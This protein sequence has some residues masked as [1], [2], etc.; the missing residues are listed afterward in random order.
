MFD[1]N[2]DKRKKTVCKYDFNIQYK[3]AIAFWNQ[4]L[5]ESHYL[6]F[7]SYRNALQIEQLA[8]WI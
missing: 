7:V 5:F 6:W 8:N 3:L 2:N 4:E 1:R